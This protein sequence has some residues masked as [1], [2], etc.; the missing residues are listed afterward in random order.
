MRFHRFKYAVR[1]L[2]KEKFYSLLNI[3]GLSIGILCSILLML[4]L[5]SELTYDRHHSKHD[6]IYRLT[7]WLQWPG[8]DVK[9]ARSARELVPIIKTEFPDA[10]SDLAFVRF[11]SF[12]EDEFTQTVIS[13][14]QS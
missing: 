12:N 6:R 14:P 5:Q 11:V 2:V 7:S 3:I 4:Y 13:I 10:F 1:I 8:S 9:W